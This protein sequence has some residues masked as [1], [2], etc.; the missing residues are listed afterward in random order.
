M[1]FARGG[2]E[3][4]QNQLGTGNIGIGNTS[5]MATLNKMNQDEVRSEVAEIDLK[6]VELKKRR[7]E[8]LAV[9][10]EGSLSWGMLILGGFG[11]LMIGLGVIALFAA[12]WD[13]FG[14]EA[15]AAIALA[16]VV[17]CGATAVWAR[18]SSPIPPRENGIDTVIRSPSDSSS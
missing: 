8:L 16:P 9:L 5:T 1:M 18:S 4:C 15:R 13:E 10:G 7:K 3:C 2:G 6:I 11:A 14:R 17:A 12:N